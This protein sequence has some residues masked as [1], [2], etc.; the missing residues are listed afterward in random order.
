MHD[1]VLINWYIKKLFFL[2]LKK[3]QIT[4]QNTSN[5]RTL[6]KY[7]DP[8]IPG[9]LPSTILGI[10]STHMFWTPICKHKINYPQTPSESKLNHYSK[11]RKPIKLH[12]QNHRSKPQ[13]AIKK[14]FFRSPFESRAKSTT[15]HQSLPGKEEPQPIAREDFELGTDG[16][17]DD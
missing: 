5:P 4:R 14:Q 9:V 12:P 8:K 1:T 13:S 10:G 16:V 15:K 6:H 11:Q 7:L 3:K 2:I 17:V